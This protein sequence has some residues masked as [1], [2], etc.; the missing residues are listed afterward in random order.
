VSDWIRRREE[1]RRPPPQPLTAWDTGIA[2]ELDSLEL[3]PSSLP[4]VVVG[5]EDEAVELEV[6]PLPEVVVDQDEE[7][8]AEAIKRSRRESQSQ[9]PVDAF[10]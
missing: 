6:S 8:L 2:Q 10:E 9:I 7:A 5:L 4:E 3:E 1:A